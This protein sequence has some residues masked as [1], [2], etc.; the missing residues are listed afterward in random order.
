MVA[1]VVG[2]AQ[3][4][5]EFVA[6]GFTLKVFG[7]N[8]GVSA[9]PVFWCHSMEVA[10]EGGDDGFPLL[11]Q[12][13]DGRHVFNCPVGGEL[14][15]FIQLRVQLLAK[16]KEGK[17]TV[18]GGDEV[19][20]EIDGPVAAW[21]YF[22]VIR[23]VF[24]FGEKGGNPFIMGGPLADYL[25][26]DLVQGVGGRG[27]ELVF[28]LVGFEQAFWGGDCVRMAKIGPEKVSGFF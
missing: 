16:V 7:R 11:F 5:V 13:L 1:L 9:H 22:L 19:A 14:E 10:G 26:N 3:E 12:F 17:H 18:V 21:R 20:K 28:H 15:G 8:G 27:E 2:A 4:H 25:A 6:V 24:V 23:L